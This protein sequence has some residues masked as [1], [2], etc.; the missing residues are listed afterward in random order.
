[1]TKISNINLWCTF[2][3]KWADSFT[4]NHSLELVNVKDGRKQNVFQLNI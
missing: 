4:V 3:Y 2:K 1:M